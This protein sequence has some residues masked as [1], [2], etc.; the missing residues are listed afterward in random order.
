MKAKFVL[1]LLLIVFS[2]GLSARLYHLKEHGILIPDEVNGYYF[3]AHSVAFIKNSRAITF[4]PLHT[5]LLGWTIRL[6]GEK[7][8][9]KAYYYALLYPVF[10]SSLTIIIVFFIGKALFHARLGLFAAASLALMEY[11]IFYG[12]TIM[13][14]SSSVFFGSL[15]YLFICLFY[16][17]RSDSKRHN[18]ISSYAF[19]IFGAM[20]LG[21]GLMAKAPTIFFIIPIILFIFLLGWDSTISFKEFPLALGLFLAFIYL[22]VLGFHK[23]IISLNLLTEEVFKSN[24]Q[25]GLMLFSKLGWN[26]SNTIIPFLLIIWNRTSIICLVFIFLGIINSL[27]NRSMNYISILF[28]IPAIILAFCFWLHI[29]P[30]RYHVSIIPF[31]ALLSALGAD[32]LYELFRNWFYKHSKVMLVLRLERG[33]IVFIILIIA[34][35]GFINARETI[36]LTT[37]YAKAAQLLLEDNFNK[38]LGLDN[39]SLR[40]FT[41][42][43]TIDHHQTQWYGQGEIKELDLLD[44]SGSVDAFLKTVPD[45]I[46]K[47]F[48]HLVFDFCYAGWVG[49]GGSYMPN[50]Q[51]LTQRYL[52]TF[53]VP[54]PGGGYRFTLAENSS[55]YSYVLSLLD[56]PIIQNIYIYRLKDL[57]GNNK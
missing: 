23:F 29:T 25:G 39:L 3:P 7:D 15:A 52:P 34:I 51:A 45:L 42:P 44:A 16:R 28:S 56:D 50:V 40:I 57:P 21:L 18:I 19:L 20:S 17:T 8:I 22:T 53:I 33:I 24:V 46:N 48:T 5:L 6:F 4:Y 26:P 37:G 43:G 14:E 36:A 55:S 47:G 11:H 49:P 9:N 27:R 12:K 35:S 32:Y 38:G 10:L 31:I 41:A 54:N 13:A 30:A 1:I 2:L